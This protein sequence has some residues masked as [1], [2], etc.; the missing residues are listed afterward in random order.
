ML[1]L[2]GAFLL[3]G[4]FVGRTLCRYLCP[5]GGLLAWCTRLSRRGVTITPDK[6]LDCGLCSNA[7]PTVQSRRCVRCGKIVCIARDVTRRVR[8]PGRDW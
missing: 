3:L 2:G 8:E 5:Y 1:M 4:M 6:E 7:V